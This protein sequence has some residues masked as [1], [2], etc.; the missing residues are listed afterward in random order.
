[1]LASSGASISEMQYRG[2]WKSPLMPLRYQHAS[3]ERDA[4]LAEITAQ[5]VPLPIA[6]RDP[7][8]PKSRLTKFQTKK[9]NLEKALTWG[10]DAKSSGGETRTLNLMGPLGGRF[11]P[12]LT[13]II[14]A[15]CLFGHTA[16]NRSRRN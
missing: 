14:P 7:I 11:V 8:A 9:F 3:K 1:M 2:R 15:R 13:R 16:R 6:P 12:A 10:N 5:Y 4:R